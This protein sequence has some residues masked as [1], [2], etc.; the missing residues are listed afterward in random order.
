MKSKVTL[1]A[2]AL[3]L[4]L[5]FG[6][7]AQAQDKTFSVWWWELPAT[8]QNKAWTKGLEEFKAKHPDVTVNFELKTFDQMQKAG[9]MSRLSNDWATVRSFMPSLPMAVK[10]LAP[11]PG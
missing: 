1:T 11:T 3:L 7:P 8:A 5:Q 6:A 9:G 10:S 4:G 2:A